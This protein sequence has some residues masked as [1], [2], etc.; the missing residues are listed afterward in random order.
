MV[1]I[2]NNL[3]DSDGNM[4]LIVEILI[5]INS[6]INITLRKLNVKPFGFD[7]EYVNNDLIEFTL[8][9]K[10]DQFNEMK[11]TTVKFFLIILNEI[12]QF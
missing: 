9:Q 6:I 4:Y 2:K 1:Y 11:T 7:K 3:I 10:L 8:Y 5:E 12:R